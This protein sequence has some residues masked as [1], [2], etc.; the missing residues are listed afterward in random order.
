MLPRAQN[1]ERASSDEKGD[2]RRKIEVGQR[3]AKRK[4]KRGL[5]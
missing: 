5:T 4:V 1:V 2:V 3:K